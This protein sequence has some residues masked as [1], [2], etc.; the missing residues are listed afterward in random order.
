MRLVRY[1]LLLCVCIPWLSAHAANRSDDDAPAVAG[2]WRGT[3]D[4]KNAWACFF[5]SSWGLSNKINGAYFFDGAH[6]AVSLYSRDITS[7]G[8]IGAA[9]MG[10]IPLIEDVED[11]DTNKAMA[12]TWDLVVSSDRESLHVT[13]ATAGGLLPAVAKFKRVQKASADQSEDDLDPI[14]DISFYKALLAD[15]PIDQSE[16]F[17]VGSNRFIKIKTSDDVIAFHALDRLPMAERLN[18]HIDAWFSKW[19]ID[20]ADCIVSQ[21]YNSYSRV[22]KPIVVTEKFLVTEDEYAIECGGWHGAYGAIYTTYSLSNG[23]PVDTRVWAKGTRDP[24]WGYYTFS[25]RVG[26]VVSRYAKWPDD[27][28]DRCLVGT[29]EPPYPSPKGLVFPSSNGFAAKLCDTTVT[30][31]W[32]AARSILTKEG[33]RALGIK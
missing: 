22:L 3:I 5:R 20:H 30:V 6:K 16:D 12:P 28:N 17:V 1:A 31:P 27:L 10:V 18:R 4:G 24:K 19:R 33:R 9:A 29:I 21:K 13:R 15:E 32:R 14:C 23:D 8:D 26:E 25:Q 2:T 7:V 11:D